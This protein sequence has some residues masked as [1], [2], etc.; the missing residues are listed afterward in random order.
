MSEAELLGL[1]LLVATIVGLI[2]WSMLKHF[3]TD[4]NRNRFLANAGFTA[5]EE[6]K[7][8]LAEKISL[9]ENNS[10]YTYSVRA[11]MKLGPGDV[12]VYFY[13]KDRRRRDD[14]YVVCEFL[15][16]VNR[17]TTLPF[18]A[19]LK[20]SSVK[21]GMAT[22]LLRSAATAGWDT[23]SDDLVKLELPVELQKSNILGLMGPGDS[24]FYDLFDSDA[25]SLLGQAGDLGITT[26]RCRGD[27][28]SIEESLAAHKWDYEKVWP[29]IRQLVQQGL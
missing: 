14:L 25:I 18:Q 6:E 20:P 24:H 1:S 19:Y 21:E 17:K 27:L 11:P 29:F 13:T 10:E 4:K 8:A 28:C 5:C 12:T 7:K 2:V 23:Q 9:L 15:F 3:K 26:I 16:T 22:K